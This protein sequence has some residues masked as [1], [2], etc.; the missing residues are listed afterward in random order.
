MRPATH[1]ENTPTERP[2]PPGVD[3]PI[4]IVLLHGLLQSKRA[5]AKLARWAWVLLRALADPHAAR[6]A[7]QAFKATCA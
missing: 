2:K 4:T 5:M 3:G 1:P 6:S 7:S